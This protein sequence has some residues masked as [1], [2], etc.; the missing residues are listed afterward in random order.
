MTRVKIGG[1]ERLLHGLQ[2]LRCAAAH[3]L[4]GSKTCS[5]TEFCGRQR[6]VVER[7]NKVTARTS[8]PCR[9]LIENWRFY[10]CRSWKI[11]VFRRDKQR[12]SVKPIF[13]LDIKLRIHKKTAFGMNAVLCATLESNQRPQA[14]HACTLTN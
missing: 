10:R 2:I 12:L 9:K 6:T 13:I 14:C 8:F 7:L 5:K 1:G 3:V 4:P 11:A